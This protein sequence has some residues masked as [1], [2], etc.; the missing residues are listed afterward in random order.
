MYIPYKPGHDSESLSFPV[1]VL[2]VFAFHSDETS[3][4]QLEIN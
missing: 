2:F 4:V 3:V 1:A